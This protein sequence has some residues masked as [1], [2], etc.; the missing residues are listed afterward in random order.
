M[1]GPKMPLVSGWTASLLL[2]LTSGTPASNRQSSSVLLRHQSGQTQKK[3][4]CGERA[5]SRGLLPPNPELVRKMEEF[6][7]RVCVEQ[8]PYLCC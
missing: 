5:N 4:V 3:H 1:P 2:K 7:R 6:R 8:K